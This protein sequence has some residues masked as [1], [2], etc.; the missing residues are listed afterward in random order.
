MKMN[1]NRF[2]I[3][4][5]RHLNK[6]IKT[7]LSTQHNEGQDN[8]HSEIELLKDKNSRGL[9][10]DLAAQ[11]ERMKEKVHVM[12]SQA[13]VIKSNAQFKKVADLYEMDDASSYKL[14]CG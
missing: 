9:K 13:S 1:T 12:H 10:E 3:D 2:D 5:Y 7:K 14:W 6:T 4:L 8:N 11:A